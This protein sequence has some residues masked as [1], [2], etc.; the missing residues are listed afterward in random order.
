MRRV[1]AYIRPKAIHC[2]EED[3]DIRLILAL[4]G[5]EPCGYRGEDDYNEADDDAP[6][7]RYLLAVLLC[8]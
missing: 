3:E 2:N 5:E 8:S 4:W 6:T 7:E 1:S